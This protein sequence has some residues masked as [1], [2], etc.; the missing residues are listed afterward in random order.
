[1]NITRENYLLIFADLAVRAHVVFSP[2]LVDIQEITYEYLKNFLKKL[3]YDQTN[4][5]SIEILFSGF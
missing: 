1:M 3:A 5:E 4:A 2:N